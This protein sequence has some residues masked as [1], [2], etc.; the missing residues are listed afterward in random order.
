MRRRNQIRKSMRTRH[1]D[2]VL[3]QAERNVTWSTGFSGDSTWLLLTSDSET[4]ISDFRYV[5]QLAEECPGIATLIRPSNLKL[6]AAVAGLVADSRIERLGFEGHIATYELVESLRIALPEIQLDSF[7]WELE[8]LRSIKDREEIAEIREAVRLA[9]RGF[10]Y[11]KSILTPDRTER[12]LAA[13]LEHALREF[14]ADGLSFPAIVAVG[15]RAAL[16]HYRA[17]N[18]LISA[19]PILLLDWGART[20]DGYCS[21]LTRTILTGKPDRKFEKIYKT[22]LEAQWVAIDLIAPG[23]RCADVDAAA[24]EVIRSAG[25]GKYFDHGLGHGI[26]LDVHESPRLSR[27]VETILQPGMVVTVEPGIYLPGWGGVRIED[28]VLVTKQ[29]AEILSTVP[30]DWESVRVAC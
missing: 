6:S 20:R 30:R 25:F 29:G 3:V 26:G 2:A 14:G 21:D 24:R 17:G 4:L 11:F 5:T 9:E 15:D 16:P 1:F 10:Q 23:V 28:D 27:Q 7:A 12:M 19:A 18:N 13:E 8:S 22:V